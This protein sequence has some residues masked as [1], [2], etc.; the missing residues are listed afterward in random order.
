MKTHITV[1]NTLV[2]SDDLGTV[3][4][5]QP[6]ANDDLSDG[7]DTDDDTPVQRADD[8][9]SAS[10]ESGALAGVCEV[11]ATVREIR[12]VDNQEEERVREFACWGCSCDYGPNI[13]FSFQWTTTSQ[14]GTP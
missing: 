7:N 4:E 13:A 2:D 1:N 14:A 5:I 11:T 12:H 6:E 3:E 10:L 8:I 9:I